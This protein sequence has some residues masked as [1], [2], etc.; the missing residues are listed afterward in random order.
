MDATKLA[1]AILM[2]AT[3]TEWL[4]ERFLGKLMHGDR[5]IYASAVVGV[6]LC[7]L[8]R[9][10]GTDLMGLPDPMFSP[11]TGEVITGL[12]VGAGGSVVH[13]FLAK[14]LPQPDPPPTP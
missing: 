3:L 4:V 12:I 14:Y 2:L 11:Y 8:F 13:L 5:M 1:L 6:G 9:L 10:D 7:L